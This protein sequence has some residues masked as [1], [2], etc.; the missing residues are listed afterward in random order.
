M[1]RLVDPSSPEVASVVKTARTLFGGMTGNEKL[2]AFTP[3]PAARGEYGIGI[4][5]LGEAG[6]LPDVL[7]NR[8]PSEMDALEFC[9]AAHKSMGYVEDTAQ[10]IIIDTMRRSEFNREQASPLINVKLDI[11]QIDHA[12]EA[13]EFLDDHQTNVVDKL[14][15]AKEELEYRLEDIPAMRR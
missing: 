8:F 15:E 1:D 10:A 6:Y 14:R 5:I 7:S 3:V 9:I 13:L 12:I 11:E 4:A 2:F